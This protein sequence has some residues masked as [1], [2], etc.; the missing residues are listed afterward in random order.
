LFCLFAFAVKNAEYKREV[1]RGYARSFAQAQNS[2]LNTACGVETPS[3]ETFAAA[4]VPY[5]GLK[6]RYAK[7]SGI[8]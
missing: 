5:A 8:G 4:Y 3:R 7:I 6:K 2:I 1:L